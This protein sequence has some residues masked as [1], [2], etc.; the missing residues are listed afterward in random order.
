MGNDA[1]TANGLV[2][3]WVSGLSAASDILCTSNDIRV[4]TTTIDGYSFISDQGPFTTL[5]P[6]ERILCEPNQT[7][8]VRTK[9]VLANNAQ[10]RYNIGV[11]IANDPTTGVQ[12]SAVDG[13]CLHFNLLPGVDGSSDK[14]GDACGDM[15][16]GAGTATLNLGALTIVC[17]AGQPTVTVN[18]CIGWEN[19]DLSDPGKRGECPNT[20]PNASKPAISQAQAFR[21][22]TLP[23]TK[24][25]CNCTPFSLPIDVRGKITIIKNTV[26]GNGTFQFS[27][28]VGSNSDPVI[29]TPF[30]I[31]TVSNTGT[32]VFD[33]VKTGTYH[34]AELTPPS[35]FTFTSLSCTPN[36]AFASATIASQTATIVMQD[37]GDITC[38]YTNTKKTTLTLVKV[39]TNNNGGTK[40]LSDFPLSAAGPTPITN[41]I[42]GSAGATN[43]VVTPGTYTLSEV[44]QAGYTASGF[45]CVGGDNA[46]P[47]TL[48]VGQSATCTISNDDQ[49]AHLT[50][51]KVVT[52]N[53]GGTKTLSD[54]PLSASGPT[55][56][57]NV[58]S[59]TS[60]ATNVP[61]N[62]GTYTPSEVTVAGY[63]A[64]A[65][66][67]TGGGAT[68][69]LAL[70][71]S[72]TC[73][74]S[75][76]DQPAHLTLVK[77]VTNNDG[78]TKTL[79]D[80]PLSATGPT[81][82]TN[83]ISGSAGATNVTVNAGTYNFS[84]VTQAGYAASSFTCVGGNNSVPLVLG[85]NHS[86]TCTVSNDDQPA[87]LTLVKVV[88]N[89]SGGTKTLS[90][91][92]LSA[93]G[94]TPISNVVSGSAGATN[95]AVSAG[96]YNFSEVTQA[97]YT[98]SA[99]TCSGGNNAVPLVLGLGQSATCTVSNDDNPATLTL[100]KVVTNNNGGTK[101]LSDFPL[102]ATGPTPITNQISGTAGATNVPVSAGTYNFSEVTV[103]GYTASAFSCS[104]GNNAVPLV[105]ALG[106]SATCT[107][108]NDDNPAHLTLVKVVTNNNGGTKTLSDF[109]LSATGPTPITN[110]ISGTA[111][112]TNVTVNAGTYNFS[113]VTNS[114][115]N[116][117]SFSC[118]GGN[119][120]VPLVLG[121][122]Q[123][124]TCTVGNDDKPSFIIVKKISQGG[125][126]TFTFA[127]TGFTMPNSNQLT[128]ATPAVA[129][130][131]GQ[132]E[133]SAGV[134]M[135]VG[136]PN[137]PAGFKLMA[138]ECT[139]DQGAAT[140][141]AT[142]V[143]NGVSITQGITI[144]QPGSI[145]TCTFD[146]AVQTGT[147]RTQ[148][149]W[150]THT[151]LS[152]TIWDTKVLDVD[153]Q[154]CTNT[155][156]TNADPVTHIA[157][158]GQNQLMGGFWSNIAQKSGKGG[159]RS[160]IDAARMQVL[161][162]YLAAVINVAQFGSNTEQFL[163]DARAI[164]C[165]SNLD[166]IKKL[167]GTL[168]AY[169]ESGDAGVFNPGVSA[170]AQQS[171]KEANIPFWDTTVH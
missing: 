153:K 82:I 31:T 100:V 85:L 121:L 142:Q 64:S 71:Q 69:T 171:K 112:A 144:T 148:G 39:V 63:T 162:Q 83:Q 8:F 127:T 1:V 4:A 17:P 14:D 107:V 123:S 41:V 78:G 97:G 32:Q 47:L 16:S 101:T 95:V 68:V 117:T 36:N 146:N 169:N 102:S 52:N 90:D 152:N 140:V 48:T 104:G 151:A 155:I 131:T 105:L 158:D 86:A 106:Q 139:V 75:N 72:A 138:S 91:F 12:G 73:T 58:V 46:S 167:V 33:K 79:S 168:G 9:A 5:N 160:D 15:N 109:P 44:T 40:T 3:N 51:V 93:T 128:T 115:Y 43:V 21:D 65:F 136:E 141:G 13:A 10:D 164:Y 74:V 88:T 157:P 60:G 42:S 26:G 66:V 96:T 11:W 133:V 25:K 18:N 130:S 116:A 67:C 98:A 2:A 147:T 61:V 87:R 120:A 118:S 126:G 89:N 45:T 80:F 20:Q 154:L 59:G 24:S 54:F 99:F 111:G 114:A 29:L 137:P 30:S 62:A 34:I 55:P 134:A 84:E 70:G 145:V 122:G 94:P 163:A 150:A 119:N 143:V 53:S 156:L 27:S 124:A 135:T 49:A 76:D 125:T 129:V 110:Q 166:A 7:V 170:T 57:S 38:T 28:D 77:V 6:G 23:E 108:S 35:D 81:P 22:A 132:I 50:L 92:P 113:E 19:S 37:G 149:F 103:A 165:G 159:K 56:I 161:Q